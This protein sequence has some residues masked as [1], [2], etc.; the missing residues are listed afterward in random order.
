M[1]P[2]VP[3]VEAVVELV[4]QRRWCL[5]MATA[6]SR[7]DNRVF[8]G[9]RRCGGAGIAVSYVLVVSAGT[10]NAGIT[11]LF[12]KSLG[13]GHAAKGPGLA[14]SGLLDHPDCAPFKVLRAT[15]EYYTVV[16]Q[17]YS[18]L[19]LGAQRDGREEAR[20]QSSDGSPC[21]T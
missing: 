20:L 17:S 6:T 18:A 8:I 16:D 4:I 1:V 2:A 15:C 5:G 14:G 19:L 3:A 12:V 9:E 10:W 13:L 7:L 21:G 11:S